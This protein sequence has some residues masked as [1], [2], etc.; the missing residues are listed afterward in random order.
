MRKS[1]KLCL[2]LVFSLAVFLLP[3]LALCPEA[4][5]ITNESI[6]QKESQ[7]ADSRK[8]KEALQ[9]DLTDVQKLKD[10]LVAKKNDLAAYVSELDKNLEGIQKKI[11]E[12]NALIAEK[13]EEIKEETKNL[14]E[15]RETEAAQYE[16]MKKRIQFMYERGDTLLMELFFSSASLGD[17]LNKADYIEA[18]SA[19]DRKM[20]D[21]YVEVT[22]Y[23]E[24]C[25]EALEAEE[26]VL[27]QAKTQVQEEEAAVSELIE[28][29]GREMAAYQSD[30]NNQEA[31]IR[32]Y[33]AQI[34]EQNAI[35]SQLEAAVAAERKRLEEE[36]NRIKYDGGVF[37]FPAPSMTRISEEYGNRIHPITGKPQFH[38]GIDIA[39]P[40]GS[41]ILA[42]YDGEVVAA[43][44]SNTM[45]N[46]IMINHGD[47]IFTIYMHASALYVSQGAKVSRGQKIAAV[48]TTGRSTG[49]HLHFSVR[50]DGSYVSPWN[51]LGGR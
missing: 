34:A 41:P 42:A 22:A 47:G 2:L 44:Y 31:V 37:A 45:G 29:K 35:I 6:R 40:G 5:Q 16:A 11:D 13:E 21:H 19:Y 24:A 32:E 51:Y 48:G 50:K 30:I 9:G 20:L 36:Q 46:Y 3:G 27:E 26:E 49:N 28:E 4:A 39:A 33:E 25:K 18:L 10:A 23:V 38:N 43:A 14:E 17:M 12:L 7:I 15:A 1:K 8:E